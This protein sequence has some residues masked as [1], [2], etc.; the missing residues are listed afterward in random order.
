[1]ALEVCGVKPNNEQQAIIETNRHAANRIVGG[2]NM[3]K[4]VNIN[5]R[6]NS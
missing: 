1:M 6:I 5:L 2:K 3:I 4:L